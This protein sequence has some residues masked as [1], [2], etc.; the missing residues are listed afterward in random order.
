VDGRLGATCYGDT[1]RTVDLWDLKFGR[2]MKKRGGMGALGVEI[3]P[4]SSL[5]VGFGGPMVRVWSIDKE[6]QPMEIQLSDNNVTCVCFA[7]DGERLLIGDEQGALSLVDLRHKENLWTSHI[8]NGPITSLWVT[9][10]GKKALTG[11]AD[12]SIR[13]LELADGDELARLVGHRSAVTSIKSIPGSEYMVS[14]SLDSTIKIWDSRTSRCFRTLDDSDEPFTCCDVSPDGAT[15]VTGGSKGSIQLWELETRWFEKDLLEPAI[16]VPKTYVELSALH[17]EFTKATEDFYKAWGSFEHSKA[18]SAF[19]RMTKAPGYCWSKE[20][21]QVRT[22]LRNTFVYERLESASFI[23]SVRGHTDAVTQLHAARDCLTLITGGADGMAYAWDVV[24]GAKLFSMDLGGRAL[25]VHAAGKIAVAFTLG[26]DMRLRSWDAKGQSKLIAEGIKPPISVAEDGKTAIA[27]NENETPVKIDL[28]TGRMETLGAT[29]PSNIVLKDFSPTLEAVHS[30]RDRSRIQRWELATGRVQGSYRDLG[31]DI[32]ALAVIDSD[33]KLIAGTSAGD[34]QV[35]MVGAG[36]NVNTI[37]AHNSAL[38]TLSMGPTQDICVSG[39]DDCSAKI[40]N[41][42]DSQPLASLTGHAA[43][44]TGLHFFRNGSII[45]SGDAD[46]SVRLWGLT[47]GLS[48]PVPAKR[49][50]DGP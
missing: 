18:L 21:I 20:A 23:R 43:P 50:G 1:Y 7:Q 13:V 37:K 16:S 33:K 11:G 45:A 25:M 38:R 28:G 30:V 6:E 32:T 48:S 31:V 27:I 14:V 36:I 12:E 19:N 2:P 24:T 3:S 9:D 5:L 34:I 15:L 40:W 44:V 17:E 8:H 26:E 41:I 42:S 46:G 4:D 47:W 29:L 35:Y 39:G 49:T 10:D 22:L